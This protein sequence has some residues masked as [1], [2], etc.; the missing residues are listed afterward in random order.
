VPA[1]GVAQTIITLL[2][3]CTEPQVSLQ[4]LADCRIA[5]LKNRTYTGPTDK[6]VAMLIARR[7][8]HIDLALQTRDK[9]TST[10]EW[11]PLG[12]LP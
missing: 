10:I 8:R 5:E 6:H 2:R 9:V 7:E 4:I 12:P 3:L 11:R 1:T